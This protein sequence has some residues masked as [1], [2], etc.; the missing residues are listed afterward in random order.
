M[1]PLRLPP[2][3]LHR[4]YRGGA[5]IARFRGTPSSDEYAP[6]DWVGSTSTTSAP[7]RRQACHGSRT[8]RSREAVAADPEAS[9][10][11]STCAASAPTPCCSCSCSTRANGSPCTATPDDDFARARLGAPRG[12]TEAWLILEPGEIHL[13]FRED[14]RPSDG[15]HRLGGCQDGEAMLAALNER[16]VAAGDC[17][18]VPARTPHA[19]GEG[20]F[21][22]EVQQ[23]SD[24]GALLEWRHRTGSEAAHMGLGWEAALRRCACRR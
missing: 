19:I 7:R 3:Q 12:K 8:G 21:M 14:R 2:N 17:V 24:L 11:R 18:Y 23:P 6:E 1:K 9:S 16:A 10:A 13:G 15:A 5:A 22:V 20:V 4:F